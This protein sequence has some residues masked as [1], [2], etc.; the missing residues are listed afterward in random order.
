VERLKLVTRKLVKPQKVQNVD[1]TPNKSGEI[2]EAVNLLVN[3]NSQKAS[4]AFFIANIGCDDFILDYPFFEAS[5]PNVDWSGGRIE[6]FTTI[7][8]INADTWRPPSKGTRRQDMTPAWVRYIPSWEEGDEIWLQ[9]RVAKTTVVQQ[10][11]EAAT[12]KKK[13]T[14]QEIVLEWYH[15]H[16]KVFSKTASEQFPD[17]RPWDHTI[18]LKDDAPTSINCCVYSLSPKEKEEQCEF[19]S[20]NLH[21]QRIHHSKSPYASGFFLIQ[22]KDGKFRPVQ[23]YRNLNK[24]TI[25][26]K[27]PLPL[28]SELIYDL[29]EK[30]VFSKFDIRWGYNNIRIKEGDK[31]TAAFKT[32]EGLFEPT[33][34]FFGL[35]NS[36]ATFQ[37]MMDDIFQEEVA[38]GWLRI[39]MDDIIITTEDNDVLHELCVNHILDKLEKFNLFLKPEKCRFHQHEVEYLGV[40]IGNGSVKMD[41]IKVQGISEW[42]IPQTVKDVQSFLG[43]CNFYRA[44]IKNFSDIARPLNDLTCKNEQ[45]LWSK[46]RNDAFLRLK[47]VCSNYPVLHTPNWSKQFVMEM[48]PS[49]Y[50]LGVVIAQEFEDG[51]H[52]IAFHSRS[53]LPAEKNYDAHDK[54]LAAVIFGFKCSRPLFLGASH[55][56]RV[57]TDH[58]N[59]QY[60]QDPWKITGHQARWIK[61]LQDFDYTL[62]HIPESTNTVADLLL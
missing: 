28:I 44:F 46:E 7:S 20:Q 49:G 30:H 2:L 8:S 33:V 26:N 21:L 40:L 10:L 5:N 12:D 62:K 38:Q 1:G 55:A 61:F 32:S 56:I 47:E 14:W 41:P 54:E 19:V 23:D 42:P 16:G 35:T 22:K 50:A 39:Y 11:G 17:R 13:R 34:M 58:K 51:V 27:Y 6:G 24:W 57:C 29:A 45:F 59:L 3:N 4:H 9:T 43:F 53:L 37:M 36:P 52:P 25:P 60:F 31:Y 48:D 18:E 15:R